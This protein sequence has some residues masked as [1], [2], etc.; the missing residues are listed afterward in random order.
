MTELRT[1]KDNPSDYK[2]CLKCNEI[3]YISN[4][5]CID[6]KCNGKRFDKRIASVMKKVRRD[7]KFYD[8]EGYEGEII[9]IETVG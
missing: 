9:D 7:I 1:I 6:S 3:N 8:S 4:K 5:S 2:I